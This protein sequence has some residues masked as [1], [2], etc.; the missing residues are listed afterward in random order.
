VL[1]AQSFTK[2]PAFYAPPTGSAPPLAV[3][4]G[5]NLVLFIILNVF[6]VKKFRPA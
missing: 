3:A 1:I 2:V 6:A 5:L 4:Q